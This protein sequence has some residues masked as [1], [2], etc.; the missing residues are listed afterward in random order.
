MT[1]PQRQWPSCSMA[2]SQLD[3]FLYVFI[4]AALGG[5]VILGGDTIA[6]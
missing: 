4:G 2:S 3:D 5:G 1:A 6:A